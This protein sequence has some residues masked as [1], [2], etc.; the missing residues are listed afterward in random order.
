MEKTVQS[1]SMEPDITQPADPGCVSASKW[2]PLRA[3]INGLISLYELPVSVGVRIGADWDSTM[4][5]NFVDLS[6]C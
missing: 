6:E 4:M 5:L 1:G 2:D 3:C